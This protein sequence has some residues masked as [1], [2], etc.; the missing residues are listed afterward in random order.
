MVPSGVDSSTASWIAFS[1]SG[2][3]GPRRSLARA[4]LDSHEEI[5]FLSISDPLHKELLVPT[6]SSP[7]VNFPCVSVLL[8]ANS[9]RC[10]T[11]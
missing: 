3:A 6:F 9:R 7:M 11:A 5:V 10:L 4:Y 2:L 8:V 1:C